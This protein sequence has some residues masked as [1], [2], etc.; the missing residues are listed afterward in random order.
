MRLT[1]TVDVVLLTQFPEPLSG[2]T[3]PVPSAGILAGSIPAVYLLM[4]PDQYNEQKGVLVLFAGH[5]F[6]VARRRL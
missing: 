2:D 1:V 6:V 3:R 4:D 5:R